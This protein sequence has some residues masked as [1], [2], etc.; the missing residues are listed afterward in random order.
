[1]LTVAGELALCDG[2]APS[3]SLMW[4]A[5]LHD[6]SKPDCFTVD[7]AGSGHFY[8]HPE[9]GA[10]KARVIMDRLALSHDLVRDVCLLIKYHDKPL[11]PRALLPAQY[12]ARAF[13][14]GR[15]YTASDGR[16]HGP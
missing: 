2:V 6:V 10:K 16:A 5:F 14:R 1:M 4:A 3:S 8:G 11:R 7:H 12:D 13:G 15:R 9:L